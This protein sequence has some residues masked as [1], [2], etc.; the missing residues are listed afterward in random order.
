MLD[1]VNVKQH[2]ACLAM[3]RM[4]VKADL[5]AERLSSSNAEQSPSFNCA[6]AKAPDEVLICQNEPLAARDREMATFYSWGTNYFKGGFRAYLQRTQNAW[7][8]GRHACGY[9]AECIG[10]AYG[11]HLTEFDGDIEL[12]ELCRSHQTDIDCKRGH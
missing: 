9:D 6:Y 7:P 5:L 2:A 4:P 8:E 3:F 1:V 10:K 11:K 12:S